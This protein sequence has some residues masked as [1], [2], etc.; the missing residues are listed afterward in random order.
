MDLWRFVMVENELVV[1]EGPMCC[2][3]GICGPE[4]DKVL[5]EL[6]ESLKRLQKEFGNLKITRASLSSNARMFIETPKVLELVKKD[7]PDILPITMV[8]GKI[9]SK[10]RYMKHDEMKEAI[11]ANWKS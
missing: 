5:I 4:P 6:N 3:S 9:I 11:E 8:N 1:F 7:G 2:S 10:Q